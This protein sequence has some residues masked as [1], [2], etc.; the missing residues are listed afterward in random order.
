MVTPAPAL[1]PPSPLRREGGDVNRFS[2]GEKNPEL[3]PEGQGS[4]ITD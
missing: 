3:A 4:P 2:L 1:A